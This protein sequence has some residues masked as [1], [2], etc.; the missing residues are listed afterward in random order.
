MELTEEETRIITEYRKAQAIKAKHKKDTLRLLEVSYS[1]AEWMDKTG[2][3][4]SFST[5]CNE[6]PH[7]SGLDWTGA[8]RMVMHRRVLE[9]IEKAKELTLT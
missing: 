1:F 4:N 2:S 3:G 5:F 9:L 8:S 7:E 6:F